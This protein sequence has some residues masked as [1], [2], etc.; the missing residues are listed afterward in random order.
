MTETSYLT[1]EGLKQLQQEIE[2]LKGPARAELSARLRAAIEMGDL[3]EN[4]DYISA[5]EEQGFLEGRIQELDAILNNVTVIDELTTTSDL[6]SIGNTVSFQEDDYPAETYMIVGR[7]EADPRNNRISYESPIGR[8]LIG[9]K[10]GD[11]VK[12][13]A[14]NGSFMVKITS[15]K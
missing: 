8:A 6:V 10:V 12:V 9:H 4:A 13:E 11:V 1:A 15:I 3:S 5:K 2:Y 7:K 14:P